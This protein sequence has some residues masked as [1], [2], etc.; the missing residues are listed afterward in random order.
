M[1]VDLKPP[2]GNQQG[3]PVHLE[4]ERYADGGAIGY[5]LEYFMYHKGYGPTIVT[6]ASYL[7]KM[8]PV[9]RSTEASV[10]TEAD[11]ELVAD[12]T[13]SGC[14]PRPWRSNERHREA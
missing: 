6:L 11:L 3:G 1:L 5:D 9:A 13:A 8:F 14:R 12:T 4:G 7:A 2:S 10:P